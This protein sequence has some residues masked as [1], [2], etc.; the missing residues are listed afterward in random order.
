ML[1]DLCEYSLAE[2]YILE[3]FAVFKKHPQ[4]GTGAIYGDTC[5][6]YGRVLSELGNLEG[7][8]HYGE[9]AARKFTALQ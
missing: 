9:L 2:R 3:T 8:I 4:H 1:H 7:A 5:L 6:T